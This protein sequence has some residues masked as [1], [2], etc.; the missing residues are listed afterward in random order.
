MD[1]RG[2]IEPAIDVLTKVVENHWSKISYIKYQLR[3][4]KLGEFLD[5]AI[6][7]RH[8]VESELLLQLGESEEAQSGQ[9]KKKKKKRFNLITDLCQAKTSIA[10]FFS[11]AD[12]G[13]RIDYSFRSQ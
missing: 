6:Q 11:L 13:V 4:L 2:P 12:R 1:S 9:K 3:I 10:E 8:S 7:S 5:L